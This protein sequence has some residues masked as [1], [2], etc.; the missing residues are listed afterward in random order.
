MSYFMMGTDPSPEKQKEIDACRAWGKTLPVEYDG[1]TLGLEGYED[2]HKN[3]IL[4]ITLQDIGKTIQTLFAEL[5]AAMGEEG[6]G[7]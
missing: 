1:L 2:E 4:P 6:F 5:Y 7:D 3:L